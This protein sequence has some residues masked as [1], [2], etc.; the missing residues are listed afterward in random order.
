MLEYGFRFL[1][2]WIAASAFAALGDN[3]VTLL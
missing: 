3:G 2:G 1:A